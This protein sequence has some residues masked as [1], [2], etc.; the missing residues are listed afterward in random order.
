MNYTPNNAL[1]DVSIAPGERR[2]I[3]FSEIVDEM[4]H[5]SQKKVLFYTI[6]PE[7]ETPDLND[8]YMQTNNNGNSGSETKINGSRVGYFPAET[9]TYFILTNKGQD[10]VS[11]PIQ[12]RQH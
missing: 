5:L 6:N 4:A 2:E 8:V 9:N 7:N 11:L 3:H 12:F 1:I 10:T